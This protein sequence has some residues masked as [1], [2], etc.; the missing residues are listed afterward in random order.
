MDNSRLGTMVT[1]EM[2]CFGEVSISSGQGCAEELVLS[3]LQ[4]AGPT[5]SH[6]G[7][8]ETGHYFEV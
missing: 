3:L 7:H 2:S 4:K 1:F 5:E 6:G 8:P